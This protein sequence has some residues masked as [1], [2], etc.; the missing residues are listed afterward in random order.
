MPGERT[1]EIVLT[2][3]VGACA[4]VK[5]FGRRRIKHVINDAFGRYADGAGGKPEVDVSVIW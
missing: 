1:R 4:H 5:I 3:S 2:A